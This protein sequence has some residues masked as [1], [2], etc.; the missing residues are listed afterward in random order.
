[1]ALAAEKSMLFIVNDRMCISPLRGG[2]L[3]WVSDGLEGSLG[4]ERQKEEA[5]CSRPI[6]QAGVVRGITVD[7]QHHITGMVP[8]GGVWMARTVV[9]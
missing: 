9:Y 8:Y 6:L 3:S 2:G 1:M 7:V 5:S 4:P